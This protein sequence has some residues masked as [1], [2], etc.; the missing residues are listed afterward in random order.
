LV[1][2]DHSLGFALKRLQQ[3]LR[4][5]M[6]ASLAEHGLTTPQYA[7]LA[8][9]AEQPG[10]SNA[11]LAR[12]SFVAAP[13]ML[14]LLETLTRA[15]L[16]TRAEPTPNQRARG[17]RLTAA[18]ESRLAAATARVQAFEDL[19]VGHADASHV[20]IIMDWLRTSADELERAHGAGRTELRRAP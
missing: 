17:T 9:L 3:S 13:T 12:Q 19:L 5:R 7:V 6:D 2:P 14:R 8:L 1:D 15:G 16:V 11:E 4:S 10:L 20:P 18:G